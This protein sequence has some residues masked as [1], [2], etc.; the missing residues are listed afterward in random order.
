MEGTVRLAGLEEAV[1]AADGTLGAE[2]AP[3]Y[4]MTLGKA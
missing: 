2:A 3:L 4:T 1:Y